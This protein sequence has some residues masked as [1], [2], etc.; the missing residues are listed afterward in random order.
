[1]NWPLAD[2]ARDRLR[3]PRTRRGA[4]PSMDERALSMGVVEPECSAPSSRTVADEP[5]E[6]ER[7]AAPLGRPSIT[8]PPRTPTR[9]P[10]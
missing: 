6:A 1:M 10:E 3:W 9:P 2:R 8:L 5:V 4:S 7:G